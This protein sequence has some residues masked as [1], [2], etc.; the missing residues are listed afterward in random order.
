M[1]LA[2]FLGLVLPAAPVIGAP[3]L[4]PDV[5]DGGGPANS[6]WTTTIPTINGAVIAGE[7]N[8]AVQVGLPNGYLYLKNDATNLYVLMD[9]TGDI[10]NDTFNRLPLI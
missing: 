3:Q 9:I 7:W 10:A 8:D 5:P 2:L 4:E 1:A 6:P